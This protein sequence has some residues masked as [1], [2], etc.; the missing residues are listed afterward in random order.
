MSVTSI[1]SATGQPDLSHESRA[2]ALAG[3]N[4]GAARM[5]KYA[6]LAILHSMGTLPGTLLRQI[7]AVHCM[8][9]ASESCEAH[10]KKK[11]VIVLAA[12]NGLGFD[13]NSIVF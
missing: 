12:R 10:A 3:G 6:C 1:G 2:A 9:L 11:P 13:L 7:T 8:G 5:E 4:G